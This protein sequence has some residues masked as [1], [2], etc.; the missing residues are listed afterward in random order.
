MVNPLHTLSCYW[1]DRAES[2]ANTRML[3]CWSKT[4]SKNLLRVN[5]RRVLRRHCPGEKCSQPW[6]FPLHGFF[7]EKYRDARTK[8]NS[9]IIARFHDQNGARQTFSCGRVSCFHFWHKTSCRGRYSLRPNPQPS[10]YRSLQTSYL[11]CDSAFQGSFCWYLCL[12]R[13]LHRF[14]G[15]ANSV[16]K[17]DGQGSD[18]WWWWSDRG[19]GAGRYRSVRASD[20]LHQAT[21][22]RW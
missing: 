16:C 11:K 9:W 12:S 15:R 8:K 10:T 3:F 7:S 6:R 18:F 2:L 13:C 17:S 4:I 22:W 20:A 21:L 1:L 19:S 14:V 5:M